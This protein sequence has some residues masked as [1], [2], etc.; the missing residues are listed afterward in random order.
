MKKFSGIVTLDDLRSSGIPDPCDSIPGIVN[1]TVESINLQRTGQGNPAV[2]WVGVTNRYVFVDDQQDDIVLYDLTGGVFSQVG[3]ELNVPGL[4]PAV[5]RLNPGNGT[6]AVVVS[7]TIRA[8]QFDGT[9]WSLLGSASSSFGFDRPSLVYLEDDKIAI[10][11]R[12]NDLLRT[13]EF[14]GSTWSQTGNS[15]LVE[16]G[17]VSNMARINSNTVVFGNNTDRYFI[18]YTFD[19]TDWTALGATKSYP[20]VASYNITFLENESVLVAIGQNTNDM[21]TYFWTGGFFIETQNADPGPWSGGQ[22]RG[23]CPAVS[24]GDRAI[25]YTQSGT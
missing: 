23:L 16:Y 3:N 9:D 18:V 21:R 11:D 14:N 24:E 4:N 6:V 25:V 13:F 5:C 8:Y 7:G 12:N 2:D 10:V 1:W 17:T 20:E 22:V 19:G 15:L